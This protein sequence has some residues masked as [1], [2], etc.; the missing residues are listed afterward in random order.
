[1]GFQF[2]GDLSGARLRASS[3]RGDSYSLSLGL[4]I[5]IGWS[6]GSALSKSSIRSCRFLGRCFG[7]SRCSAGC[8]G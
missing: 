2:D 7:Y 3:R 8:T 1:M 4:S 6:L 5:L